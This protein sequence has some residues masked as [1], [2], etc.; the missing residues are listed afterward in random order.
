MLSAYNTMMTTIKQTSNCKFTSLYCIESESLYLKCIWTS[1]GEPNKDIFISI[2]SSTQSPARVY[3]KN[4][5]IIRSLNKNNNETCPE[6][7]GFGNVYILG[8]PIF[9]SIKNNKIGVLMLYRDRSTSE[10]FDN[11]DLYSAK[12]L[13]SICATTLNNISLFNEANEKEKQSQKIL[14]IIDEMSGDVSQGYTNIIRKLVRKI[15]SLVVC[16]HIDFWI[17]DYI[18]N[19]LKCEV[20]HNTV[21]QDQAIDRNMTNILGQCAITGKYIKIDNAR[22]DKR[23]TKKQLQYCKGQSILVIHARVENE[24]EPI[25]VIVAINKLPNTV[26][27]HI[28]NTKFIIISK[29]KWVKL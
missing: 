28:H 2:T 25:A 9:D 1:I 12:M 18:N 10:Q 27:T 23:Y 26:H 4:K 17:V 24:I 22:M 20:S 11:K 15:R 13:T 29:N 21:L 14:S 7:N 19:K 16:T 8:I 3:K 6:H 5:P